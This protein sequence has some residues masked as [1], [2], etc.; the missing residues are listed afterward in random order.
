MADENQQNHENGKAI[1]TTEISD[2]GVAPIKPQY[3][4]TKDQFHAY[5]DADGKEVTAEP[6]KTENNDDDSCSTE[7]DAKK[8]KLDESAKD[9]ENQSQKTAEDKTEKKRARGQNKSR[10]H[11]KYTQYEQQRLCPSITQEC[12]SKCFFG[13][14]CK[15]LHDVEKYLSEK[16]EDIG[17]RCHLYETLG[18]CIYG[19]T[20]RFA[21]SHLGE[22]YKN[23]INQELVK[24]WEGKA[25]V[26]NNLG[27]D[28][29]IQLRK[30]KVQFD[31]S[32]KFLKL[33]NKSQKPKKIEGDVEPPPTAP[34]VTADS[35]GQEVTVPSITDG[36]KQGTGDSEIKTVTLTSGVVTDEDIIKLRPCE[37]KKIDFRNKL[38]LAPLTTCGNLPFRR[39]CKRFGVDITCGEMAMCT[40]L[41]QGHSS[42]WALVKRHQSEDLF[43]IQ[44]EGAFPD[45]MTKC[46]ELLNRTIDVDFVDINVGCPIDLVYNKGGGCG[47]MTRTN[48][49]EN[50]VR[51]MNSVLDVPL[52]VKIRTGV[53][54]KVSL[55]HKLIPELR[56]WGVSLVTLHGRS[57][58][59]RYTK[60]ADWDYISH[61]AKIADPLPFFGNGDIF[62]FE[63]ANRA[64][65]TGVSGIML[66]RGALVKPWLFTE[67]K[68]QR[69]WDISS[70]ER[71]DILKDFTNYGLEHWGSDT[72]GVEKTRRFMLEW[73]SF[74]CRYI[75]VG[76]LERLPQ[77]IN[78]RPPYYM[79][80]DY[81]ETLMTSQNV[82]DW[83]KISEMLLGPVPSNFTFLPKHKANSYK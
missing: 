45:T 73:L 46:A 62:S 33:M 5:L 69:H 20:C 39:I 13:E 83:I 77:K 55:A 17:P 26:K 49:F 27:K 47:L 25:Q 28:L 43:G 75:P 70:S 11:V 8:I 64:M 18:K 63:D 31:K 23:L 51:G 78:E 32:D 24:Q 65:Q 14:K 44:L 71:F 81:L 54:E 74:L 35:C 34:S 66:A 48:K 30:R 72:P 22:G 68:E 50:I 61:C 53:Q 3:L 2:R 76:L 67:I 4:T 15:F 42:E 41:L 1:I 59:Q 29:Q 37:K 58:E 80:R 56:K 57:R 40:N 82:G 79:G 52:T 21:K 9:P 7:P 12:A 60:L 6:C 19:I 16:S 38:Y 10:P 36:I